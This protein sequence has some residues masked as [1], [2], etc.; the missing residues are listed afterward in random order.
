MIELK[1]EFTYTQH[2]LPT[3]RH[4]K[5]RDM[6]IR[7]SCV[8]SIT[9]PE[10][11]PVAFITKQYMY[12]YE[13]AKSYEDFG[14]KSGN[15]IPVKTEIRTY[16]G[17]LYKA[18]HVSH[19]AAIS[20]LYEG[21]EWLEHRLTPRTPFIKNDRDL[22][23]NESVLV[24]DNKNDQINQIRSKVSAYL[25]YDNKIWE[26]VGEPRYVINTFGLGHNHGGTSAFIENYYNSNIPASN[27]FNAL[28][29]KEAIEY[30][31]QVALRRGDTESVDGMFD[32]I[33]IQVLMP[34]M[35][36][37]DPKAQHGDGD[38]FVNKIE[39]MVNSS[40]SAIEASLL[41]I[42]VTAM[43]VKK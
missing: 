36:K 22:F 32:N 13:D 1:V 15:Y 42:M 43:E 38:P 37:V 20:M 10:Y 21:I 7:D 34:E 17:K 33:D 19:G 39:G 31:K 16:H 30:G 26:T 23:S 11:F 9:E 35:V 6:N 25:W 14:G 4:R 40:N 3:K 2:F 8:V 24:D 41:A 27:Y 28:Q 18:V 29:R 5:Q 12:V